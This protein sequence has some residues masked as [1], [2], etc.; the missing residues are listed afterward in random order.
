MLFALEPEDLQRYAI[1]ISVGLGIYLVGVFALTS[2]WLNG[3]NGPVQFFGY[4]NLPEAS[5]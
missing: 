5:T 4:P 2:S 1:P 3:A